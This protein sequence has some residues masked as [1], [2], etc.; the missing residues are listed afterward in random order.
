MHVYVY[1]GNQSEGYDYVA[2]YTKETHRNIG[3][4]NRRSTYM[5]RIHMYMHMSK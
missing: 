2:A 3:R 4:E 1:T 5:T